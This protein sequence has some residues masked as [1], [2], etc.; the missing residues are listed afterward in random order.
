MKSR[1]KVFIVI[2]LMFCAAF[3]SGN[4]TA[5]RQSVSFQV[6]YDQLSPYGQWVDYPN[7]GYVWI[8]DAGSDFVP[9]SSQ[10]YWILTDYGWTWVS[11][12]SWGWAPFHYGRWDYDDSYGWFWVPDNEWGPSWVTWRR[13]DGYYGW[14]PMQ[15]GISLSLSFGSQY[16][17]NHDHWIFVRDRDFERSDIHRYN[18]D[19]NEHNRIIGSSVVINN[20]YIDNSRNTTYVAGPAR[21]EVQKVTGRKVTPVPIRENNAPGQKVQNGKME[22]YRP[23]VERAVSNQQ[24]PVPGRVVELKDA[25]KPGQG[26]QPAR[27]VVPAGKRNLLPVDE[28]KTSPANKVKEGQKPARVN[29]Q[30][31]GKVQPSNNRKITPLQNNGKQQQPKQVS[32]Q[33][34]RNVQPAQQPRVDPSK[35]SK[36]QPQPNQVSPQNNRK[37]QPAQQPRVDPSRNIRQ[38]QPPKQVTPQNKPKQ[39]QSQPSRTEPSKNQGKQQQPNVVKPQNNRTSPAQQNQQN[40]QRET[41]VKKGA[42]AT[43]PSRDKENDPPK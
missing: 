29:P 28:R 12:Y 9:Y 14:E 40:P 37:S 16:D 13:A 32:P 27:E 10:G 33:N 31:N 34:N 4:I 8:P 18:V 11:D 43:N 1:T 25:K 3:P 7:Y 5:Q 2:A 20:T 22:I 23:K 38:D 39:E 21:T 42:K 24:K 30:N 36:Q 19:R 41:K 17:R 15:P 26:S 35:N 6:F